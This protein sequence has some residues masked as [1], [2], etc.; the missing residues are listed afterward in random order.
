[1]TL[2]V[3]SVERS[4]PVL[5]VGT[6]NHPG[7]PNIEQPEHYDSHG[8]IQSA[9]FGS[10]SSMKMGESRPFPPRTSPRRRIVGS[11]AWMPLPV[12]S[13][14][15]YA[16]R[17]G[18]LGTFF[19][20]NVES[21]TSKSSKMVAPQQATTNTDCLTAQTKDIVPG[22]GMV[23]QDA[24]ISNSKMKNKPKTGLQ[25]LPES[26]Y[27]AAKIVGQKRKAIKINVARRDAA[28]PA[29]E[30]FPRGNR[31]ESRV[32]PLPDGFRG[33][34]N[35]TAHEKIENGESIKSHTEEQQP[36]PKDKELGNH[37]GLS[38]M[39]ASSAQSGSSI[40]PTPFASPTKEQLESQYLELRVE[41]LGLKMQLLEKTVMELASNDAVLKARVTEL[42]KN[43][44][45][46]D[47]MI[48]RKQRKHKMAQ[49]TAEQHQAKLDGVHYRPLREN[50]RKQAK[51]AKEGRSSKEYQKELITGTKI[52]FRMFFYVVVFMA[53]G[54]IMFPIV[55][56]LMLFTK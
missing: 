55:M 27:Q 50:T 53:M 15:Q 30:T 17:A 18:N 8:N 32:A 4:W 51:K 44:Q 23:E 47:W 19:P 35:N 2:K 25:P 6:S 13:P 24:A 46:L 28:E 45:T 34:S 20:L 42:E 26:R 41:D 39:H 10:T 29:L 31:K 9:G 11:A 38:K 1:M 33:L 12:E 16:N 3:T 37:I 56:L 7:R 36:K 14:G 22:L 5:R 21:R 40:P 52:A 43:L 54:I 48:K 49:D